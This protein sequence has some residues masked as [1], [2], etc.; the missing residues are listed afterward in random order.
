[1]EN[2]K[3]WNDVNSKDGNGKAY[4]SKKCQIKLDNAFIEPYLFCESANIWLGKPVAVKPKPFCGRVSEEGEE[5]E[6]QPIDTSTFLH[7]PT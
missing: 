1:M 7:S 3:K 2:I 4:K 6:L 5:N